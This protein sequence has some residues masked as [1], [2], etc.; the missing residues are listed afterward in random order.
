M[1]MI[2]RIMM[3]LRT[4]RWPADTSSLAASSGDMIL[5]VV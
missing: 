4:G 1:I 5:E 2:I 3:P